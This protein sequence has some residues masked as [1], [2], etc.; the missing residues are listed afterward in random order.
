[1]NLNLG[2]REGLNLSTCYKIAINALPVQAR[3]TDSI[4]SQKE[5]RGRL[6]KITICISKKGRP[7]HSERLPQELR[8][9][10]EEIS[11]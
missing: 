9:N 2:S 5:V 6:T 7:G 4:Q 11:N 3:Y 1:M 8:V 10:Y